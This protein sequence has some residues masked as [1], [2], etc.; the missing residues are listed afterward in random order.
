MSESQDYVSKV[1]KLTGDKDSI[2][3]RH[4]RFAAIQ[5]HDYQKLGF[6]D[7]LEANTTA[8]VRDRWKK[9]MIKS[10]TTIILTLDVG[11]LSQLSTVIYNQSKMAKDLWI[12]IESLYTT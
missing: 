2:S 5:R 9:K 4:L 12:A 6:E 3:W 1:P 8:A 7:K 10:K 11:L